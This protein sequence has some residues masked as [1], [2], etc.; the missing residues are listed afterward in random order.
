MGDCLPESTW[1][2]GDVPVIDVRWGESALK[3]CDCGCSHVVGL[4]DA[5]ACKKY[6]LGCNG[7]CVWCDH[8]K[9]CHQ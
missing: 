2:R 5:G 3:H 1:K 9:G 7:R 8:A 4:N 6:A